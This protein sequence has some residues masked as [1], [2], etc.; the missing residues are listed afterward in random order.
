MMKA[1]P[2]ERSSTLSVGANVG[3][4]SKV[5]GVT[6]HSRVLMMSEVWDCEEVLRYN[7]A[8]GHS[9]AKLLYLA[10]DVP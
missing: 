9:G 5:V 10:M 6:R 1:H 7:H 2:W 8:R 4:R 3:T